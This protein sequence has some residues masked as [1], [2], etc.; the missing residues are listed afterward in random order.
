MERRV[1]PVGS[2]ESRLA[3]EVGVGNGK[4]AKPTPLD[5]RTKPVLEKG[6]FGRAPFHCVQH[7]SRRELEAKVP[8]AMPADLMGT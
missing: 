5:C 3:C 2:S 8:S 7:W 6:W 1:H 4:V